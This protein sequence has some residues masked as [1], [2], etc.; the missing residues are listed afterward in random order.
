MGTS[1]TETKWCLNQM[2]ACYF[3]ED[4]MFIFYLLQLILVANVTDVYHLES[5]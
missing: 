1:L 4:F 5:V 3:F 2:V